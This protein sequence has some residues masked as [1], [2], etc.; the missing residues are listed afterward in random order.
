MLQIFI[1]IIAIIFTIIINDEKLKSKFNIFILKIK[2]KIKTKINDKNDK[3]I[4]NEMLSMFNT[5]D[6]I[7]IKQS[8]F[9]ELN[10]KLNTKIDLYN[11]PRGFNF[12]I[13]DK[14]EQN[15][16][17]FNEEKIIKEIKNRLK[18]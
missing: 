14:D 17:L 7:Y 16:K 11:P 18:N 10:N 5:T 13:F 1:S 8:K 6:N 3:K 2:T 4:L 15:D 9:H 12:S